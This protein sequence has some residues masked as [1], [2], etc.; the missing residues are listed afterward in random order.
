TARLKASLRISYGPHIATAFFAS[1]ASLIVSARVKFRPGDIGH[2]FCFG[3]NRAPDPSK[4]HRR[5]LVRKS[6]GSQLMVK[7]SNSRFL[8]F[9]IASPRVRFGCL[10]SANTRMTVMNECENSG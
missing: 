6:R 1:T 4:T 5:G 7:A 10:L 2:L 9:R 3:N 8:Y